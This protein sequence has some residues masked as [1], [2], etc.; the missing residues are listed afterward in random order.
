MRFA[1]CISSAPCAVYHHAPAC[2]PPIL[3]IDEIQAYG[4]MRYRLRRMRYKAIALMKKDW[5]IINAPCALYIICALRSIS[6][7]ASVH[8]PS[9]RIDEIQAY[10]LMRYR[11]RRMRYKPGTLMIKT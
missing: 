5:H 10:G 7:R 2:I 8:T 9:L 3:R 11:L 1:H 4:L 6:S